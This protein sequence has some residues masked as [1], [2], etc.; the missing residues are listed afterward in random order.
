MPPHKKIVVPVLGPLTA[1]TQ[2]RKERNHR[3]ADKSLTGRA[4][5][6]PW[7]ARRKTISLAVFELQGGLL[8]TRAQ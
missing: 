8:R 2:P 4:P 3:F 6:I 5:T 7:S 1:A